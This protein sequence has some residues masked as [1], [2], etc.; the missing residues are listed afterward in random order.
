MQILFESTDEDVVHRNVCL[1][2]NTNPVFN[3][4]TVSKRNLNS[5]NLIKM[6]LISNNPIQ[7]LQLL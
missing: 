3:S 6:K 5:Q 4:S 7:R 1:F 2:V